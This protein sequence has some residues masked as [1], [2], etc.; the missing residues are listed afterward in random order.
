[1]D[2]DNPPKVF[3][4]TSSVPNEGKSTTAANLAITFALNG[5]K[6]LVVE[7]DLRLPRLSAYMGTES[8]VGL[9]D[10]LAGT[11]ELDDV[12][13]P[14]RDGL[15]DLLPAGKVPPNPSELLGSDHMRRLI[16]TV[17]GRYDITILDSPPL[18]PVT[19]A[20]IIATQTDGAIVVARHNFT[21]REQLEK[22]VELLE[23]V[24]AHL[25]G[26]IVNFVP[27]GG[28]RRSRT[29]YGYGY[30]GYGSY[31]YGGYGS[32]G[33][34]GYGSYGGGGSY[35]SYGGGYGGY[36]GYEYGTGSQKRANVGVRVWR[37]ILEEFGIHSRREE[38]RGPLSVSQRS[39]SAD[40]KEASSAGSSDGKSPDSSM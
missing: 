9:T 11:R 34:G 18:L 6:V 17:R 3:V 29:G 7:A 40:V 32:Y 37:R 38:D 1:V 23:Q 15:F 39:E 13:V 14:F 28:S 36:G 8:S 19:D 2:V 30:G 16:N 27:T 26:T 21:R 22:S 24:S 10:V 12:I 5:A 33:Y 31:G 25:I 35:G 20:A 4:I